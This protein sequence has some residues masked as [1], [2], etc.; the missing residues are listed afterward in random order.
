MAVFCTGVVVP[1]I[2]PKPITVEITGSGSS[3]YCYVTINGKKYTTASSG[4]EVCAG[5]VVTFS[6]YADMYTGT[7]T[8]DGKTVLANAGD[9]VVERYSWTV[10]EGITSIVI[11][12]SVDNVYKNNGYITVTTS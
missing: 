7:V 3:Q 5:D 2:P 12:L 4:I 6:I 9:A 8:I 11:A 10:P 1:E